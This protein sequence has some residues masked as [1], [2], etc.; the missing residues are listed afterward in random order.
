MLD[1]NKNPDFARFD[2]ATIDSEYYDLDKDLTG[3]QLWNKDALDQMIEMVLL[4]EPQE[5]LFNLAFGSPIYQI[6]F[7]NFSQVDSIM[8][9]IFD[10]I[11]HW[12]PITIDRNNADVEQDIDNNALIFKIPYISNNGIIRGLFARKVL[13]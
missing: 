6:L 7:D 11:E 13:R 8:D 5:R 4:T 1:L 10:V 3:I 12:V 2:T 9:T